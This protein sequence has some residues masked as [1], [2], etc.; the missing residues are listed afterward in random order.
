MFDYG[1]VHLIEGTEIDRPRNA[2][3]LYN[4]LHWHFGKFDIFFTPVSTPDQPPHTYRIES[5]L[6]PAALRTYGLPVARTLYLT[7]NR[8]IDPPSPRLLALHRAIAHVLHLSA[9]GEYIDR[10]LEDMGENYHVMEDGS[11]D[12]GHHVSLRLGKWWG[13]SG[14]VAV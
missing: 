5:F 3:T 7:P 12:L 4:S 10:I 13:S 8:T 1:I 2:L 9:A 6:G 14:S 11:T